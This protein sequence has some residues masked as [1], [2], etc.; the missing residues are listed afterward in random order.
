MNYIL[1]KLLLKK[2]GRTKGHYM[3][4]EG[5]GG[6]AE[7]SKLRELPVQR[8]CGRQS[9]MSKKAKKTARQELLG[10]RRERGGRRPEDQAAQRL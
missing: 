1:I 3:D 9:G 4:L 7:P 5:V 8:S 2:D 6:W 10:Q